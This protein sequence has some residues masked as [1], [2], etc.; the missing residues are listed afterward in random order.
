M[1]ELNAMEVYWIKFFQGQGCRLTNDAAGGEGCVGRVPWNK[2]KPQTQEVKDKIRISLTGHK[3]DLEAR[4]NMGDSHRGKHYHTPESIEK[5]KKNQIGRPK[6]ESTKRNMSKAA[7]RRAQT[8]EGFASLMN[9]LK[10][11]PNLYC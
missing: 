2:G 7:S 10:P 4:Q 9:R 8:P 3:H 1:S 5:I 6:S 11:K